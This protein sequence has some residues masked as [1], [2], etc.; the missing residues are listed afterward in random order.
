MLKIAGPPTAPANCVLAFAIPTT[1]D[2]FVRDLALGP[3]KDFA[4]HVVGRGAA[5]SD[6]ERRALFEGS[7]YPGLIEIIDDVSGAV[8]GWGVRV[9]RDVGLLGPRGLRSLLKGPHDVVTLVTHWRSSEF[10][11]GDFTDASGLVAGVRASPDPL[12]SSLRERLPREALAASTGDGRGPETLPRRLA[13]GLNPLIKSVS[14]G[15]AGAGR[16]PPGVSSAELAFQNRDVLDTAYPKAIRPGNRVEFADGLH[17]IRQV[18]SE[19]P[20]R[21]AAIL[22]LT[23]CNSNVLSDA[24]KDRHPEWQVMSNEEATSLKFRLIFYKYRIKKLT[25][26]PINYIDADLELRLELVGKKNTR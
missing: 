22:D 4:G 5:S 8:A 6:A 15:P 24:I 3:A 13:E 25:L 16:P 7:P 23:I 1:A 10:S 26:R 19:I 14:L 21:T 11:P 9:V 20:T 18:V 2:A 12:S 17:T